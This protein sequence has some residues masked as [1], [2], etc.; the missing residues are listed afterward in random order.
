MDHPVTRV[1]AVLEL[2]QSHGRLSGAAI[3]ARLGVDG[4]TVRRYIVRLEEMGIPITAGRGPDGGYELVAGYKLPPLLFTEGEALAIALG[5][6][7]VRDL[8][9]SDAVGAVAAAQAKLERVLSPERKQRVR[10]LSETVAFARLRNRTPADSGALAELSAA[11]HQ[12]QGVRLRYRAASGAVTER[13]FDVYGLAFGDGRWYAAGYCHLRRGL[14][15]F[16]LDRVVSAIPQPRTFARPEGFDIVVHLAQAIAALPRRFT[17]EVRL[18]TNLE[19][20]HHEVPQAIGILEPAGA[21]VLLRSQADDLLWFARELARLPFRFEV[22]SP[23]ALAA[24]V[25]C[26]ARALLAQA[27]RRDNTA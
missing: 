27:E 2:L 10:A 12:R 26:H 11:A 16:R 22:R 19:T 5:L 8:E 3:A 6:A 7:A 9:L 23:A 25:A 1:L 14:R 21:G 17:I 24:A 15:T 20:A 4:R 18:H 13:D